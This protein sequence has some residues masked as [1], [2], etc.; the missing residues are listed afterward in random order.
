MGFK[1]GGLG[2]GLGA[3]LSQFRKQSDEPQNEIQKIDPE[4]I[5][6]NRWQPRRTFDETLLSELAESIKLYGILQP[7]IVRAND[8]GTY[9]LISGERRLRAS[10]LAGLTEV[11]ALVREFSDNQ[12]REIAIIENVQRENLNP[13]EEAR[14]Y[15]RL[16]NEFGYT[17][18]LLASKIGCST[19]RLMMLLRLLKLAPQV[20]D[21]IIDGQLTVT[22]ALPLLTIENEELQIQTAEIIVSEK[23]STRKVNAFLNELKTSGVLETLTDSIEKGLPIAVDEKLLEEEVAEEDFDLEHK[24][25][26]DNADKIDE[27]SLEPTDENEFFIKQVEVE[28]T[29]HFGRK[30]KIVKGRRRGRVQIEFGDVDDLLILMKEIEQPNQT[31]EEKIAALRRVS[32]AKRGDKN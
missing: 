2:K 6:P 13:V 4:K 22:Q 16:L 28:L 19:T 27:A 15:E 30:V 8:D 10:K 18:E 7:L 31:K 1:R 21:F 12:V 24:L 9:E 3:L 23:L 32:T 5:K 20:Q 14:A 25:L 11:P 17:K 26:V 29:R